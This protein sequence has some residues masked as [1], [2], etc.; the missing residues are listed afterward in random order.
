MDPQRWQ[1]LESLFEAALAQ[2]RAKR[3]AFCTH[4]C[5]GDRELLAEL[6]SLLRAHDTQ[7]G[8]L[9][10]PPSLTRRGDGFVVL[11]PGTRVGVW[12]LGELIGRGGAGEVY[13]ATRADG[14]FEQR[15]AL[16][17]L[18]REAAR[19]FARFQVERQILARLEHPGIARLLD[20]GLSDEG[21]PYAVVEYVEGETLTEHCRSRRADLGYRLALFMQVCEVV[22][23]A[24][25]NLVV[26]RDLK[27]A[28]ILVTP[29]GRVKLLDFGVAKRL[30][31]PGWDGD[32]TQAPLTPNYAAPEQLTGQPV[33]SSNSSTPSA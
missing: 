1:R 30:D 7:G 19:E 17:L 31:Q 15:V 4:E 8:P 18:Q 32:Q 13:E 28:N 26:H 5:G 25:R 16:K 3:D 9:D 23:Y 22:A 24:H 20:G 27:P 10:S 14:N 12:R 2:P 11:P 21:R 6:R 33:S 29:E